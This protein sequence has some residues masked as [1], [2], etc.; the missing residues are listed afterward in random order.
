MATG[1]W[2]GRLSDGKKKTDAAFRTSTVAVTKKFTANR[3]FIGKSG[4]SLGITGDRFDRIK[5][6]PKAIIASQFPLFCACVSLLDRR[7][8]C[9]IL[10]SGSGGQ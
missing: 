9:G 8:G 2:N 10:C 6:P 3:F 7:K 5:R 1:I 4:S